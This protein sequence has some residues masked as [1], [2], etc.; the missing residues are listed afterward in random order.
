MKLTD[1]RIIEI[2]GEIVGLNQEG[3]PCFEADV[4]E[5]VDFA[6]AILKEAGVE[7]YE[8]VAWMSDSE[9]RLF[10]YGHSAFVSTYSEPVRSDG[11]VLYK[12]SK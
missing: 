10:S 11:I 12:K 6:R 5:V 2:A 1:K 3:Y 4:N 9:H 8:P 7:E